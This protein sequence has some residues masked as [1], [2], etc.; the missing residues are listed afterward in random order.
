MNNVSFYRYLTKSI[1]IFV[2]FAL[3]PIAFGSLGINT[4]T[5]SYLISILCFFIITIVSAKLILGKSRYIRFYAIVFIVEILIGLLHYL[6][7]VD[8]TYFSTNGDASST[9]WHEY[10]SVYDAV[11]RLNDARNS[12]GVF[13]WMPADEFQVTHPEIWHIISWPFYFLG[14]KWLN[15]SALNVFCCLLTS[16]NLVCLYLN[17]YPIDRDVE[18]KI[19]L[20]TAFFP[21]FLLSGTVWRD[22]LG[23]A[24]I[25]VGVV[26][27]MLSRS[28]IEKVGS[29]IL[30]GS[31]AFAQRTV[32]LFI[33]GVSFFWGQISRVKSTMMKF[34]VFV[35]GVFIFYYLSKITSDVNSAEYNSGYINTMSFIA[36]PIKIIF[37]M[38]GPFP[39]IL[40]P[41]LVE[42]N[43]AF[44]WQLQDYLMGIFQLGFLFCIIFNWKRISFKN[45][46]AM[47]VMG[48]GIMLSGLLTKQLHIGYVSEGLLFTLPWFFS[49]VGD[50]YNKYFRYSLSVLVLLNILLMF[51]G[52]MSISSLWH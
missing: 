46:D 45:L 37:G 34:L 4:T 12:Y 3:L 30:Y 24:L 49:Q 21:S 6:Y 44:A 2:L 19:R 13:Y 17:F 51:V 15:Y 23:I 39:W 35:V 47:T 29:L 20:W 7:F 31:F 10:L 32:Y 22:P 38:I 11:G 26:F 52:N 41:T 5:G 43:P 16:M 50:I 48:L 14:N 27:T 9:F 40:F 18:K 33:A 8:S 1:L 42:R 25:S 28:I 36:L